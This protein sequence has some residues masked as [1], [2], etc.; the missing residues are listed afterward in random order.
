MRIFYIS[1][2]FLSIFPFF[3]FATS[4]KA[5]SPIVGVYKL[6]SGPNDSDEGWIREGYYTV[7][8]PIGPGTYQ[9]KQNCRRAKGG[10]GQLTRTLVCEK[11]N[12]RFPEVELLKFD[13]ETQKFKFDNNYAKHISL[14]VNEMDS[15]ILEH[16][17]EYGKYIYVRSKES[18]RVIQK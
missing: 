6:V 16:R 13:V 18:F 5:I 4:A 2:V 7:V 1:A 3:A 17:N 15:S 14:W 8:S 11:S 9:I 12:A 10:N